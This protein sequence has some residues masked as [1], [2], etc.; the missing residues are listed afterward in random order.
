[1]YAALDQADDLASV[2]ERCALPEACN[3]A[4]VTLLQ[5]AVS[6]AGSDEIPKCV[7][8]VYASAAAVRRE[9]GV[10]RHLDARDGHWASLLNLR[11]RHCGL[12]GECV[13][14]LDQ[15]ADLKIA[16][17]NIELP[18]MSPKEDEFVVASISPE[19][20]KSIF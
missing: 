3:A 9:P 12:L 20:G 19:Q 11:R 4:E 6:A 10:Q 13:A 5:N 2:V 18:A 14:A 1:M 7:R 16:A 8:H 17:M 15:R